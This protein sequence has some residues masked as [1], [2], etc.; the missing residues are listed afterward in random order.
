MPECHSRQFP[1]GTVVTVTDL[2]AAVEGLEGGSRTEVQDLRE[3]LTEEW[4]PSLSDQQGRCSPVQIHVGMSDTQG[5]PVAARTTEIGFHLE[6]T[7]GRSDVGP[8]DVQSQTGVEQVET[9]IGLCIQ[10]LAVRIRQPVF[11]IE[12]EQAI[13][14]LRIGTRVIKQISTDLS[15][16]PIREVRFLSF[17]LQ[18][19]CRQQDEKQESSYFHTQIFSDKGNHIF[20]YSI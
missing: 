14:D 5:C 13:H 10:V 18:G 4:M 16:E 8:L 2:R 9:A 1:V 15:V 12:M 6:R 19:A 11:G 17:T 3:D 7:L 20:G